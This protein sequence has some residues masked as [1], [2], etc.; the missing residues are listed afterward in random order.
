MSCCLNP[1]CKKPINTDALKRC[2]SCGSPLKL[3]R[4]RYQVLRPLTAGAMGRTYLAQDTDKFDE[5]CAIKQLIFESRNEDLTAKVRG[6]FEKEARQLQILNHPQIPKLLA[7]FQQDEYFYLVQQFIDGKDLFEEV[8]STRLSEI[9]V[10]EILQALLPV[11]QYIH[12]NK[13]VH[14]D[15]KPSNIMRRR[16]DK[17]LVLIDFGIAKPLEAEVTNQ[18]ATVSGSWGFAPPEQILDGKFAPGSDLFSLGVTCFN[19]LTGVSPGDLWREQGYDW[20]P[21]WRTYLKAPLSPQLEAVMDRLLQKELAKRYSSAATVL[22]DLQTSAAPATRIDT[23]ITPPPPTRTFG[24]RNWA[25]GTGAAALLV[26]GIGLYAFGHKPAPSFEQKA[27]TP[28]TQVP[29]AQVPAAQVPETQVPATQVPVKVA[30]AS[31]P[32]SSN[33]SP[34]SSVSSSPRKPK[35]STPSF[36]VVNSPRYNNRVTIINSS[37]NST[38]PGKP[39][40]IASAK[41]PP[42]RP[43]AS[44]TFKGLAIPLAVSISGD[45]SLIA[46]SDEDGNVLLWQSRSGQVLLHQELESVATSLSLNPDGHLLA[47]GS[48]DGK[49]ALVD[50]RSGK[51]LRTL[52]GQSGA[53]TRL[54]FSPDGT[55]LASGSADQTIKLWNATS[56]DLL[57]SFEEHSN[58]ITALAFS[59]DGLTL[60]SS[61]QDMS[62]KLWDVKSNSSLRT[63]RPPES[64]AVALQWSGKQL[65]A[66]TSSGGSVLWD[67]NDGKVV[68]STEGERDFAVAAVAL[69]P[70]GQ[71]LALGS[72][73]GWIRLIDLSSGK[74]RLYFRGHQGEVKALVYRANTLVS[75]GS[76][77]L[78]QLWQTGR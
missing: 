17:S 49:V 66:A 70:D 62:V 28:M 46:G 41:I 75:A 58:A 35:R 72:T 5:P 51:T 7:Y 12:E 33:S 74:S 18:T 57:A 68:R 21:K 71:Q 26:S 14:R 34:P 39:A 13:V 16:Q 1:A 65:W 42:D 63:L 77:R 23:S 59:P 31:P 40:I 20:L 76:D 9:Q 45:G 52:S 36:V 32:P 3:L 55:K 53:I 73:D 11:L 69:R 19:F 64:P 44:Q 54:T 6:M 29:A 61:S 37:V 67:I 50:G 4:N 47:I 15:L 2:G 30:Q 48:K 78:V 43:P 24:P 25:I 22:Q 8:G 38:V 56:G 10:R 60:A 27:S